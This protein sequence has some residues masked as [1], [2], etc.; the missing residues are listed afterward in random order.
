MP[1]LFLDGSNDNTPMSQTSPTPPITII[2]LTLFLF[3]VSEFRLFSCL[4]IFLCLY[5]ALFPFLFSSSCLFFANS[6]LIPSF[7]LSSPLWKMG[8]RQTFILLRSHFSFA[9]VIP[10][11]FLP[12]SCSAIFSYS[13]T[14]LSLPLSLHTPLSNFL[15][16]FFFSLLWR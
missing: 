1:M 11:L 3:R 13:W 14:F 9:S 6:F 4:V 5:S 16:S 2:N 15:T 10:P 12:F 7:S 8:Y